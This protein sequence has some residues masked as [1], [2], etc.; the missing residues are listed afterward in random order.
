[1]KQRILVTGAAGYL[2][3]GMVPV[4]AE[5]YELRLM[6]V[7]A[8]DP[9]G[10]QP[11]VG[12][13]ADL[14]AVRAAV[15]GVDALVIAHMASR[16]AGAYDTPVASFDANVK[17]TAN[18]FFAA[19][20]AGIARVVLVSSSSVTYGHGDRSWFAHDTP[21]KAKDLYGLT[22]VCQ[23]VVAEQYHRVH[24]IA[25]AVLRIGALLSEDTMVDKYGNKEDR[26]GEN[27]VDPR[28]V[29]DVA[30][31]CLGLSD[32]AY[33]TLFVMGV[34]AAAAKYDTAWTE[35]RL[36]WKPRHRYGL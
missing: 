13:V 32:L 35:R 28:D 1:M 30:R 7:A 14:S 33:E 31:L 23:E 25:V 20:E 17:G 19:A 2:G 5:A 9:R 27:Y 18:L 22:K 6:D 34:P 8:F 12:D 36:G 11:V 10:H 16:Q 3:R 21:P 15:N 26:P 4:L 29:G 24:G